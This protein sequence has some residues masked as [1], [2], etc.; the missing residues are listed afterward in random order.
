MLSLTG[1][2]KMRPS[3]WAAVA[4]F[5]VIG[6][7]A[8]V[9]TR[10]ASSYV[11]L[12]AERGTTAGCAQTKADT[13]ASGG[14]AV[15]FGCS[16]GAGGLDKTGATIPDTNY[17]IP[18]GAI[19]MSAS[20]ADTNAGTAPGAPVKTLN[21]AY[22]LV[23]EGGTIVVRGGTYRDWLNDGAGRHKI[24][25]KGFTIQA[26]PHEQ[27][28][29]DGADIVSDG[30]ASDGA[31]RWKRAWST[32]QFCD[33]QYYTANPLNQPTDNRGACAHYDIDSSTTEPAVG[34]PQL[35]W[36]NG[37]ELYQVASLAQVNATSFYYD[38]TN[39]QIY[40]GTDPA[41][42]RVELGVRPT[43]MVLGGT[44]LRQIRGV[45]FTRYASN[46]ADNLTGAALYIGGS[47]PSLVESSVLR[48]NGTKGIA[49]SNPRPGSA[50]RGN[51]FAYNGFTGI[52]ANGT[53]DPAVANNFQLLNNV[54]YSNNAKN[55]G[56][57][58]TVSCGSGHVKM[59]NMSG[60]TSKNNTFDTINADKG[61]A[62]WCDTRC[63]NGVTINN[64]IMNTTSGSGI[65]YEINE[66]GFIASN[67]LVGNAVGINIAA[68]NVRVY[69]NTLIDS[70]T[71]A[72][73][74]FDDSRSEQTANIQL[75]NN[76]ISGQSTNTNYFANT[77]GQVGP[78]SFIK[79]L[80]YN[81][82]WRSAQNMQ[83]RWIDSS[84]NETS[85]RTL[86]EFRAIRPQFEAKSHDIIGGSDPYFVNRVTGDYRI[87][88]GSQAYGSGAALPA[89]I[90]A[91][92]GVPASAGQNRGAFSWPGRL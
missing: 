82:Y 88:Q 62:F 15:S 64:L 76:V 51:V 17:A 87:R 42:K 44:A 59:A 21:R 8:A 71:M 41:G 55:F 25:S 65:F 36:V 24:G 40:I 48:H 49:Y 77:G 39:R 67:V 91:T 69:N 80:D 84:T 79:G 75:F 16:A 52:H 12:E 74:V 78:T 31:G 68:G 2:R 37:T 61:G 60:Y 9:F 10:A 53:G 89:D 50:V 4:L 54:F 63:Y 14:S 11:T 57:G 85:T 35:A 45:G 1:A 38:W 30:W 23:P 6:T 73:R 3:L 22:A 32:P 72:M 20:G 29:F 86:A 58:C 5:A 43:A 13:A 7:A 18:A 34:D 33:G 27:P 47:G 56:H 26:Y 70:K 90:A 81:S 83:W 19:Y 28:W 92:L 46:E 66:G